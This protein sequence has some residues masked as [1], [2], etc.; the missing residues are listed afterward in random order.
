MNIH[1]IIVHFPIAFLAAYSL[2]ELLAFKRLRQ[3]I[4]WFYIKA[5]LVIFGA[6]GAAAAL[7]TGDMAEELV[8]G[9]RSMRQILHLHETFAKASLLIF[10]FIAVLYAVVWLYKEL[11]P[12]FSAGELSIISH[13]FIL[14]VKVSRFVLESPIVILLALA[15]LACI[16]ITGGLGGVMVHGPDADPFFR[17]IYHFLLQK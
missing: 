13:A 12:V 9:D 3:K 6:A 11:E 1:T 5:T 2:L 14:P 17:P 10:S 7:L 16:T 4:Y 15:G 8:E